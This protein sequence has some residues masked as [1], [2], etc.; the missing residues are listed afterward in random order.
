MDATEDN[1]MKQIKSVS[2]RQTSRVFSHCAGPRVYGYTKSYAEMN[3]SRSK[4]EPRG[5]LK[6]VKERVVE[7]REICSKYIM[8]HIKTSLCNPV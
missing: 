5:I 2:E 6:G 4:M 3:E 8:D 7:Y 1:P